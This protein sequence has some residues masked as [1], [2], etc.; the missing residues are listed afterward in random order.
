MAVTNFYV[1][2]T[3]N[4]WSQANNTSS[5]TAKVYIT[6]TNSYNRLGTA[7]GTISFGGNASGSFNFSNTF[8]THET[9]L[10]YSRTFT[11]NHNAD[12]SGTVTCSV[13]FDTR[14]SAGVVT[15]SRSLTL[16]KIP[17]ASTPSIS[18]TTDLGN[19]LT[20]N[21]N[22]ATS[23]YTHT[24]SYSLIGTDITGTIGTGI[25]A[26]TKWTPQFEW[27]N[28]LTTQTEVTCRLTTTT[29]SGSTVIGT[30]TKDF[31]LYIPESMKP[32][33]SSVTLEDTEGFM[34]EYNALIA[35]YS[36]AK[37]TIAAASVYGATIASYSVAIGTTTKTQST[38]PV[39]FD[40]LESD[41]NLVSTPTLTVTVKD[42]RGR[43]ATYTKTVTLATYYPSELGA[44]TVKR[45]NVV[46]NREDDESTTVRVHIE[47]SLFQ[48]NGTG[49]TS[50]TAKVE[51]KQPSDYE[52]KTSATQTLAT[53]Y[54]ANIDI[55]NCDNT[56][57][58]SV[59]ITITDEFGGELSYTVT[60]PTATPIMDLKANG[61]GLAFFGVS[62][63]DGVH[64]NGDV[65][66]TN[67]DGTGAALRGYSGQEEPY[68]LLHTY[69]RAGMPE[70]AP[71]LRV[72]GMQDPETYEVKRIA[73]LEL[74]W[75]WYLGGDVG[76][77][78]WRGAWSSGSV[79]IPETPK[80][81]AFLIFPG[82]SY[83]NIMVAPIIAFRD[84]NGS[85]YENGYVTGIGIGHPNNGNSQAIWQFGAE[86]SN[87]TSWNLTRC[88]KLDHG[89]SSP[90]NHSTG[91]T[92]AVFQIRG[93]F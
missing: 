35:G 47:G 7:K 59:K 28:Q 8:T 90:Y 14:V 69:P 2:L 80:Y 92:S 53:Q 4:S 6:T 22:R 40:L 60:V 19:E 89:A 91:Q 1:T 26:S 78:I 42:T 13:R 5:V 11:V 16:H 41:G 58:W 86:I 70:A 67:S 18:G 54:N 36:K 38:S 56:K 12:G 77:P 66:L 49:N 81:R 55:P 10:L 25:G 9:K 71:N 76:A 83:S 24:V 43:I 50:G 72:G 30:T 46:D 57:V 52:Y 29:Y 44:F 88:S 3:E 27:A 15:A 65:T 17:R 51:Y 34:S 32:T 85:E 48:V 87:R 61:K 75:D 21:M 74:Y 93:L 79:T 45:W 63:F 31:K 68:Y 20:I 33:I 64:F 37:V 73:A 84:S 62:R 82:T 23:S 39:T